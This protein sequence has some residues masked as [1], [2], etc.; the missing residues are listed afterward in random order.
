MCG[1]E[2]GESIPVTWDETGEASFSPVKGGRAGHS[3]EIELYPKCSEKPLKDPKYGD[4]VIVLAFKNN[5]NSMCSLNKTG[6]VEIYEKRVKKFSSV[7][8][9][10]P[11]FCWLF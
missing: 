4:D 9:P 3:K 7:H 6:N 2:L 11:K 5:S 10:I 1:C 8:A